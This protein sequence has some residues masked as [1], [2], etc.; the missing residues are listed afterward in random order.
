MISRGGR[1]PLHWT[2]HGNGPVPAD[3]VKVM[4]LA[5][6]AVLAVVAAAAAL[7]VLLKGRPAAAPATV[8]AAPNPAPDKSAPVRL[9]SEE[10][11]SYVVVPRV[12]K[13]DEQW[14]RELAPLDY[15]VTREAG[16]ERAFTGRYWNNHEHGVYKC[17]ACGTDLFRSTTKFESGTG[18]PSFYEPI[19]KENVEEHT[20]RKFFMVRTE[21]VC[22]RCG[23]HLGHVFDD[24]PKPTGLRYCMNSAALR[25]VKQ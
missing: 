23:A 19:A 11:K 3:D 5:I 9:W 18:W 4:R 8:L 24:G 21:V 7:V 12:V 10:S 13:S 20:D 1:P 2:G 25:F 17:V 15:E 22:A 16:T 6:F 14:K